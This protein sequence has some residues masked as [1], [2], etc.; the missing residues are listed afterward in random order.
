MGYV[1][2]EEYKAGDCVLMA[3]EVAASVYVVESGEGVVECGL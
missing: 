1:R 2:V 3:G